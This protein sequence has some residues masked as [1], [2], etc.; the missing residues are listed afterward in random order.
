MKW[1][2]FLVLFGALAF[3]GCSQGAATPEK[4]EEDAGAP[5]TIDEAAEAEAA[6]AS[7][8]Q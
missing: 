1:L 6:A 3:I 8:A 4:M 2:R 7:E 5:E